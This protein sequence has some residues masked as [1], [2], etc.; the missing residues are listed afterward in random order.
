M[1]SNVY[2]HFSAP[3]AGIA[4]DTLE[5]EIHRL[6]ANDLRELLKPAR[7][8][9]EILLETLRRIPVRCCLVTAWGRPDP[10]FF[11]VHDRWSDARLAIIL[12][13]L[14]RALAA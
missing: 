12:A 14:D 10:A 7:T 2:T 9:L 1:N 6:G 3:D 8:C 5:V 4:A 11:D 13:T